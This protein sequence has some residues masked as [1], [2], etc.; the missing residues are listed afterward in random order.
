MNRIENLGPIS[1]P[2]TTQHIPQAEMQQASVTRQKLIEV[3]DQINEIVDFFNNPQ[4]A[5]AASK[6]EPKAPAKTAAKA[7]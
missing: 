2:S 4:R 7:E 6:A 3:I 5:G 1:R